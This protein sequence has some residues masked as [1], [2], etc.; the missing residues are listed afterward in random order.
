MDCDR[1]HSLNLDSSLLIDDI[2]EIVHLLHCNQ[3]GSAVYLNAAMSLFIECVV[4]TKCSS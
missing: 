2:C 1:F 4:H 3:A